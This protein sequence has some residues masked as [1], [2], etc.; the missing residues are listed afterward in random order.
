MKSV[1]A[2]LFLFA[3]IG[4]ANAQV[5]AGAPAGTTGVCK[6]GTYSSASSKRG[7][8]AGHKGVKDW[9]E[10]EAA[11]GPKTLG[12]TPPSTAHTPPAATPSPMTAGKQAPPSAPMA[13]GNGKV[14]VN[15]A[16]KVYHCEGTRYYGKTK[17]GSYMSESDAVAAGNRADHGKACKG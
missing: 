8:C 12:G 7:A 11:T 6:D 1:I 2:A 13:G 3:A 4:A 17:A 16:S 15:T 14:W 10:A 9:Y 5:P